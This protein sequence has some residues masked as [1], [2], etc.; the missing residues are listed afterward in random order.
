[1]LTL[2]PLV[3]RNATRNL[4]RTILTILSIA[5]SIFIFAVLTSLPNLVNQILR[6]RASSQRLVVLNK[7]GYFYPLPSA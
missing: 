7:G 4:R 2:L 1:M 5:V 6:E 3:L